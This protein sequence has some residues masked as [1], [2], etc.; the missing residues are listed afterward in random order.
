MDFSSINKKK[1]ALWIIGVFTACSLIF[2]GVQNISS[3]MGAV[4]WVVSL[5]MP[6]ILGFAFALVL[7]VPLRF[8]ENHIFSKT[9]KPFLQKIR[10]PLAFVVSIIV[11]LSIVAGV[12]VLVIPELVEAVKVIVQIVT[13]FFNKISNLD[14]E[15]IE[16]LPYGEKLLEFIRDF[17]WKKA[18]D[19]ALDWVKNRGGT[20]MNTAFDTIGSVVTGVVNIGVALV[21]ACYVLLNKDKLVSQSVRLVKAWLPEKFGSWFIYAVKVANSNFRNF[22]AGQTLEAMI[23]GVLCMLGMLI[24]QIPYAPMVGALVGVTA[25]IPVVGGFIGVGIGTVMILTVSP[26]KAVIFIVFFIVLQNVEG[27][28]IYPKVM[29]TR[30]KLPAMWILAA[31]SIGGSV[32]GPLGMLISVPCASTAYSLV[33]EATRNREKKI[34]VPVSSPENP[35]EPTADIK[36]E[37]EEN[38]E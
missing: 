28:F 27:N 12:I 1:L 8:F 26:I 4:G 31:V 23:L 17:D 21:F 37:T 10:R 20:I 22:I 3:V 33:K 32:A 7:D 13:D 2:L 34:S 29:G 30:V 35:T 15:Q 19:S 14:M 24:L 38:K 16:A 25:L 18:L 5:I 36:E 9:K 6:I 11:I